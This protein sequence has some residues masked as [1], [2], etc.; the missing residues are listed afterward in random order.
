VRNWLAFQDNRAPENGYSSHKFAEWQARNQGSSFFTVVRHPVKRAYNA[1]MAKIFATTESGYTAIRKDL[2][3][4]FGLLLPQGEIV[5]EHD[6][7]DLEQGG[8]GL[9][10]HRICFKLF[11]IFVAANLERKT[12][13][14]QDGKWQWQTEIIRRYRIMHPEVIVIK[15]DNLQNG[16]RYLENRMNFA[17]DYSWK[18]SPDPRYPFL[19]SEIYDAEIEGL[20]RAAYDID[21]QVFGYKDL[22]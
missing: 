2:E 5:I 8:Y 1:F 3:Q 12:K 16:L 4:E 20:T 10:A 18:N 11:L 22:G 14:R 13:I 15:E 21:Y 17:R 19:L 6:R 7:R 9:E